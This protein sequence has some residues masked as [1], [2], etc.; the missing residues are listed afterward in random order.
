VASRSPEFVVHPDPVWRDRANF[1]VNARLA[2]SDSPQRFEQLWTRQV[3]DAEFEVC[4]IPF[5]VYDLALGDVVTTAPRDERKYV[6]DRVLTRSGRYTFRV[7]FGESPLSPQVVADE[8]RDQ[9]SL[10]EW[11]SR[12]LLAVDAV[13]AERAQQVADYLHDRE[14]RKELLYETGRTS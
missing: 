4:C 13:D 10:L 7:W 2:E 11:S 14:Q 6:L 9:G 5:F 8:L 3:S 12:N 1:I